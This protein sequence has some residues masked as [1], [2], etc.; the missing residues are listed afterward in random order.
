MCVCVCVCVCVCLH[1]HFTIPIC[2]VKR[3]VY[4][5]LTYRQKFNKSIATLCL[6]PSGK[7]KMA[8]CNLNKFVNKESVLCETAARVLDEVDGC[9]N[10]KVYRA[11][12][13][14]ALWSNDEKQR[15]RQRLAQ[16]R[17]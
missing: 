1:A 4:A 12:E 9:V 11:I 5:L 8:N 13:D 2:K 10:E 17:I 15:I 7:N 6:P 14:H 16:V 3:T